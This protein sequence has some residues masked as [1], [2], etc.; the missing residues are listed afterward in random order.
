MPAYFLNYKE[1]TEGQVNL[2]GGKKTVRNPV[3]KITEIEKIV[4]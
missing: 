2:G 4:N 1:Q 3:F